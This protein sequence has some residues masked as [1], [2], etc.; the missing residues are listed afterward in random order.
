MNS[1]LLYAA[2]M[3]RYV[4]LPSLSEKKAAIIHDINIIQQHLGKGPID[5]DQFE[6]LMSADLTDLQRVVNDQAS[7]LER[8][9]LAL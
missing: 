8:A 2:N 5:P 6:T 9:R 4:V 3:L 1:T 7:A